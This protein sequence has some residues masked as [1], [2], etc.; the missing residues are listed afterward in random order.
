[1]SPSFGSFSNTFGN[2]TRVSN[3]AMGSPMKNFRRMGK[4]PGESPVPGVSNKDTF[5]ANEES[6][7]KEHGI[8]NSAPQDAT[9]ISSST[10]AS[11]AAP[12]PS[13]SSQAARANMSIVPSIY[14]PT[15][16]MSELGVRQALAQLSTCIRLV[17]L[18]S[19][20]RRLLESLDLYFHMNNT[21]NI[22]LSTDNAAFAVHRA[23]LKLLPYHINSIRA[24]WDDLENN[25]VSRNYPQCELENKLTAER[26]MASFVEWGLGSGELSALASKTATFHTIMTRL[27]RGLPAL[28]ADLDEML[29]DVP[30]GVKV[31]TATVIKA[32]ERRRHGCVFTT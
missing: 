20:A 24:A 32:M 29:K 10:A 12:A 4:I 17:D 2:Q 9:G 26:L 28:I 3:C 18:R 31:H 21:C 13:E 27:G 22:A 11:S 5:S 7:G 8:L 1:M 14:A 25:I 30:K 19:Q 15:A 16:D 6:E 23:R